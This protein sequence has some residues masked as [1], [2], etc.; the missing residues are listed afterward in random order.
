MGALHTPCA[1]RANVS[2]RLAVCLTNCIAT[3]ELC[4]LL[5]SSLI[6]GLGCKWPIWVPT[7]EILRRARAVQKTPL[8]GTTRTP[9]STP[10][11]L[12]NTPGT[13]CSAPSTLCGTAS[14]LGGTHGLFRL[15]NLLACRHFS[16]CL[17]LCVFSWFGR[18]KIPVPN[19][20]HL[21]EILEGHSFRCLFD[22]PLGVPVPCI[23]TLSNI[24]CDGGTSTPTI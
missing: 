24:S 7:A 16:T 2:R 6:S 1:R 13:P 10:S 22:R 15:F 14:T 21:L 23:R 12:C 5:W 9:C 11:T 8:C 18:R 3:L 19:I 20:P 4:V 17:G